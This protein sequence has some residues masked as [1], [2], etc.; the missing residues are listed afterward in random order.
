[1]APHQIDGENQM[2]A[3]EKCQTVS[4]VYIDTHKY[5]T[6]SCVSVFIEP[7]HRNKPNITYCVS[8]DTPVNGTTTNEYS[9]YFTTYLL[10][11]ANF[12]S[13][14]FKNDIHKNLMLYRHLIKGKMVMLYVLIFSLF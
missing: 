3:N 1:M 14:M 2:T 6:V 5:Q 10:L 4:C 12:A 9:C 13:R 7:M 8:V 11:Q